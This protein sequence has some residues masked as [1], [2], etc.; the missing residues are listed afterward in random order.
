MVKKGFILFALLLTSG[1]LFAKEYWIDVRVQ[2]QYQYKHLDG[3]RN[4]PLSDLRQKIG[5]IVKDKDDTIHLYCNS[6]NQSSIAKNMLDQLGYKNVI[7]E[8]GF[9]EALIAQRLRNEQLE[10]ERAESEQVAKTEASE[11]ESAETSA[12]STAQ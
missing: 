2:Q 9:E 8:G 5:R 10:K 7:D 3:A 12:P 11:T 1:S 4:L 6:G